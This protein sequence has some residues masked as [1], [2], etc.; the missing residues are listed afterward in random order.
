MATPEETWLSRKAAAIYLTRVGYPISN[1]T[2]E[3]MA[4]KNN[5]GHGPPYSRTS[6]KRAV[7]RQSDL[8][9]WAKARTVRVE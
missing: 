6:W 2:L 3:K 9:T 7:Y 1:R 8:D 4:N 5:S